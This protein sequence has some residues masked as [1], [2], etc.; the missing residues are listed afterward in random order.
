M[1][2]FRGEGGISVECLYHITSGGVFSKFWFMLQV[3][4]EERKVSATKLKK[5][6]YNFVNQDRFR[7]LDF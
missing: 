3:L 7:T 4:G 6:S 2:N 1:V 5:V